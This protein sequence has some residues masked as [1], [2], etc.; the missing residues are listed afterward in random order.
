MRG[1][2][3]PDILLGT[4]LVIKRELALRQITDTTRWS[5]WRSYATMHLWQGYFDRG[6]AAG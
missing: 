4:D 2:A 6:S 1:L 3:N 5:P